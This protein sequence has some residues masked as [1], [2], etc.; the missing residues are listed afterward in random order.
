MADNLRSTKLVTLAFPRV[1]LLE[2]LFP[3]VSHIVDAVP[4]RKN[5][6]A[7]RSWK[8]SLVVIRDSGLAVIDSI[9][10]ARLNFCFLR[11]YE[12]VFMASPFEITGIATA[13]F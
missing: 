9:L 5:G 6:R 4:F 8:R 3:C 1:R 2:L 12:L 10:D 7:L 11:R 13:G